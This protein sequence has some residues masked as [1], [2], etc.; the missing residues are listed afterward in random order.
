MTQ[1]CGKCYGRGPSCMPIINRNGEPKSPCI[2]CGMPTAMTSGCGFPRHYDCQRYAGLLGAA[3]PVIV[4]L[5]DPRPAPVWLGAKAKREAASR[6]PDRTGPIQP[7][8]RSD[9]LTFGLDPALVL[10]AVALW[11][12]H[13]RGVRY[14]G[15]H[16]TALHILNGSLR[17]AQVPAVPE[18]PAGALKP[19]DDGPIWKKRSW[20]TPGSLNGAGRTGNDV[21]AGFDVNGNFH[22]AAEIELGMGAPVRDL[23][24]KNEDEVLSL[25]GWVRTSSLENAPWSMADHWEEG[26][27][28]PVPMAAYWRERGAQFLIPESLVWPKH[29]RWLRTHA[30]L[31]RDARV[32][33]QMD[34]SAAALAVLVLLKRV[35]TRAFGGLLSSKDY[36]LGESMHKE[37]R[38]E[39]VSTAQARFFRALD[40]TQERPGVGV[41]GLHADAAWFVMP[42]GFRVPPNL[43]VFDHPGKPCP[44]KTCHLLGK[45]KPA[46]RVTWT[47]QL[48]AAWQDG[49]HKT[50]WRALGGRD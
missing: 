34:G 7:T 21:L 18:L 31:L 13:M 20:L 17:H 8:L 2:L 14:D 29:R 26:M 16:S 45:F 6:A 23:W 41:V 11:N 33:L 37:A 39:V 46:G 10:R 50:L 49:Q 36:N 30:K 35:T 3:Q 25:P 28:V 12:E 1:P 32:G 24:P 42:E 5:P 43:V 9:L 40:K 19:L 27:W 4:V 44:D 38:S 22:G 15:A 47:P 48:T